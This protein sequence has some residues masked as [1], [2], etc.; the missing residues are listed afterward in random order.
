MYLGH[1]IFLTGLTLTLR[2]WL[3]ALITIAVSV[4]FHFRVLGDERQLAVKLGAP[5]VA[6][7]KS[8]KRWLPG[9]F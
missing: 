2:S 7:T 6:Y 1:V 3:A 8:V 9:L 5:Y 4:W